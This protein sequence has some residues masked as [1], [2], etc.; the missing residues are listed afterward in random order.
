MDGNGQLDYFTYNNLACSQI[1]LYHQWQILKIMKS[2]VLFARVDMN[3]III[4]VSLIVPL[5]VSVAINK[6]IKTYAKDVL[7][8]HKGNYYQYTTTAA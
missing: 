5:H 4:Y 8:A 3:F 2:F 1:L 7:Q 6:I